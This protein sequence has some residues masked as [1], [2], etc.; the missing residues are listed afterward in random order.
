[1]HLHEYVSDKSGTGKAKRVGRGRGSGRGKTSGR[2]QTGQKS[3]SG[4]SQRPGFESGHVPL[5]R[6]LPIRGFNN[7]NFR[8]TYSVVN[9]SDLDRFD[10]AEE[11][12][13]ETLVRAGLVRSNAKRIKILGDGEVKKSLKVKADMFTVSA[14]EKLEKAGGEAI[15]T[16]TSQTE[17]TP[18]E[19]GK[20]E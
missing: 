5:L 18:E 2:G 14:R 8:T 13:R 15:L 17:S 19:T 6:R 4:Y 10:S 16:R 20:S 3:R 12:D 9:V 11:I 7:Y 1:M